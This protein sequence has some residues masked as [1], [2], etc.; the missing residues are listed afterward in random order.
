MI[1]L[2]IFYIFHTP[3]RTSHGVDDSQLNRFARA[4]TR[5]QNFYA[6]NV[7]LTST[8]LKRD[9]DTKS[10]KTLLRQKEQELLLLKAVARLPSVFT[11]VSVVKF[12]SWSLTCLYT[13]LESEEF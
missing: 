6:R 4:C 11:S 10:F 7:L 12:P 1:L 2:L 9:T 3:K 13:V 5:I 8:L